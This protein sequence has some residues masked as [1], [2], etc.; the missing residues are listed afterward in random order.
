VPKVTIGYLFCVLFCV[1]GCSKRDA[2]ADIEQACAI[3]LYPHYQETRLDQ[4]LEVC[5]S[6]RGGNTVTCSTSCKLKGAN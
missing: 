1:P 3:K 6:C 2:A 5:K 4:C